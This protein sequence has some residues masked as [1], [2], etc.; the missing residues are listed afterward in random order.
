[1]A[2]KDTFSQQK[3]VSTQLTQDDIENKENIY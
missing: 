3:N 1:M 2:Y